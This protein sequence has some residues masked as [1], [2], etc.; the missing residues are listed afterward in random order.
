MP[1]RR[2]ILYANRSAALRFQNGLFDIFYGADQ[3]D[4]A[5]VD[6]LRALFDE[7]S[8]AVSVGICDL[9][10]DLGKAESIGNQLVGI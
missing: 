10:F 2:N 4:G 6:L 7:T 5:N 3:S 1:N 9:L 8:P